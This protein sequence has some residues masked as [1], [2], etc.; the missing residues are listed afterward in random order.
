MTPAELAL[1][2]N[3]IEASRPILKENAYQERSAKGIP[4]SDPE[5]DARI[6]A[7]IDAQL[8]AADTSYN[9][10]NNPPPPEKLFSE[11]EKLGL[12]NVEST[13]YPSDLESASGNYGG[14]YIIFYIN[15]PSES[16]MASGGTAL[17]KEYFIDPKHVNRGKQSSIA[18][19][20]TGDLGLAA[21]T[22]GAV[23]AGTSAVV[24]AASS[25]TKIVDAVKK[26]GLATIVGGGVGAAFG[27]L[28]SSQVTGYQAR[29]HRRLKKAIKLHIPN[30]LAVRYASTYD[31]T[32]TSV[33]Q[34][35]GK[36][37]PEILNA[38]D[39]GL[40]PITGG[41][42]KDP[43]NITAMLNNLALSK[44]PM[45]SQLS[46]A[47]GI[48][49][50]PKTESVFK[51]VAFRT[52][53]FQYT[54]FPRS[55]EESIKVLSIIKE[56]KY[57]MHPEFKDNNGFLFIF[58]SEFDIVYYKDDKVNDKINK[59]TS[60]VLTEM[61]VNYTPNNLFNTFADGTPTQIDVT[62]NFKELAILTKDEI[63]AGY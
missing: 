54:F 25:G 11:P 32:D 16:S 61:N 48:S 37:G 23:V 18:G 3:K 57:H 47:T 26:V 9:T 34:M 4:S 39:N 45:G 63:E 2:K 36:V 31:E 60:C 28:A 43:H 21:A 41:E 8:L 22:A 44:G 42:G 10:V 17:G 46:A 6:D 55:S 58:P 7:N 49:P 52:F 27:L 51:N 15:V 20:T 5:G 19:M 12:Y 53:S 33:L 35:A 14:N 30:A 56:F 29:Q 13:M 24:A 50:N 59:H 38:I 40:A 1:W 62:L